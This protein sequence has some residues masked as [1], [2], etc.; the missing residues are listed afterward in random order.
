VPQSEIIS[1]I[2]CKKFHVHPDCFPQSSAAR[3][4]QEG[5]FVCDSCY[6]GECSRCQK[7]LTMGL[8]H[9]CTRCSSDGPLCQEHEFCL[10]CD[11]ELEDFERTECNSC[12]VVNRIPKIQCKRCSNSLFC[13]SCRPEVGFDVCSA[14][15]MLAPLNYKCCDATQSIESSHEFCHDCMDCDSQQ[16]R[17]SRMQDLSA[18]NF[19]LAIENSYGLFPSTV[20][21]KKG[22]PGKEQRA[23]YCTLLTNAMCGTSF[24]IFDNQEKINAFQSQWLLIGRHEYQMLAVLL[25]AIVGNEPNDHIFGTIQNCLGPIYSARIQLV[26]QRFVDMVPEKGTDQHRFLFEGYQQEN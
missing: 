15:S 23:A 9:R 25:M 2:C 1:C 5:V 14:C 20:K 12:H 17:K 4:V 11:Q 26:V 24:S 10:S 21:L 7:S 18:L 19:L 22:L 3:K 6:V 13:S 16:Y 8:D